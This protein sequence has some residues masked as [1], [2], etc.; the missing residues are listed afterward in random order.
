MHWHVKTFDG[1]IRDDLNPLGLQVQIFPSFE[2]L[3][4]MFK[5]AWENNL[6]LCSLG[7]MKLLTGEYQK[8][9]IDINANIDEIYSKIQPLQTHSSYK[10]L[11]EKL[12]SHIEIFN[13]SILSKKEF[14]YLRDKQAFD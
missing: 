13:K 10:D 14:K 9:L 3:D 8:R 6:I 4:P 12:K 7:M 1:C 5:I 11:D 2:N